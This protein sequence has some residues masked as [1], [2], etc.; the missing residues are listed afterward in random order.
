MK[1][2]QDTSNY[3]IPKGFIMPILAAFR[4][5]VVVKKNK[6]DRA[7]DPIKAFRDTGE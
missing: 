2:T 1:Y 7:I 6:A 3:V 4:N 5:L